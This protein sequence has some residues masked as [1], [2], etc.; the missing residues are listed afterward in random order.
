MDDEYIDCWYCQTSNVAAERTTCREC[1]SHLIRPTT[2]EPRLEVDDDFDLLSWAINKAEGRAFD[3]EQ[4]M[5]IR[6]AL[7]RLASPRRLQLAK[8]DVAVV[9]VGI[10]DMTYAV[11]GLE[12]LQLPIA[13]AIASKHPDVSCEVVT[14]ELPD[15]SFEILCKLTN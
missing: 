6:A 4:A 8:Q 7:R 3:G 1:G 9:M 11:G 14:G 12:A 15:I 10:R 5:A 13:Q 2:Q